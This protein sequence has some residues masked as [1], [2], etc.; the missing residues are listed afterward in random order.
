MYLHYQ[1]L[2]ESTANI[3]GST[4]VLS[5][6]SCVF[7]D[8]VDVSDETE[9][10]LSGGL[11]IFYSREILNQYF[12]DISICNVVSTRNVAKAGANFIFAV[13]GNFGSV[14]ITNSTSSMANYH[15]ESLN[16]A[17]SGFIYSEVNPSIQSTN[18]MLLQIS[19][20]KFYDNYGGDFNLL[21]HQVHINV[22]YHAFIKEM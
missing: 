2:P 1:T 15:Y 14:V 8:G 5:I 4:S 16:L 12:V 19:D 22:K 3:T 10:T 20:S 13:Y 11:S 7:G 6:D 17:G 9:F 21:L 18:K